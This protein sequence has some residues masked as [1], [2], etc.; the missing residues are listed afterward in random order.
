[1]TDHQS[2]D[3]NNPSDHNMPLNIQALKIT[4]LN[5]LI[6]QIMTLLLVPSIRTLTNTNPR[7]TMKIRMIDPL[8]PPKQSNFLEQNAKP[9]LR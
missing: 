2:A 7:L 9:I 4:N 1:M 5:I 8:P 3:P 6:P